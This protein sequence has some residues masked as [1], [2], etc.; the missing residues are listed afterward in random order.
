MHYVLPKYK[1]K[2]SKSDLS[3]ESVLLFLSDLSFPNFLLV[4]NVRWKGKYFACLCVAFE[5]QRPV[6]KKLCR[7]RASYNLLYDGTVLVDGIHMHTLCRMT[8][9]LRPRTKA[10]TTHAY[11]FASTFIIWLWCVKSAK[12][13]EQ[14]RISEPRFEKQSVVFT[15]RIRFV[16][17]MTFQNA[18]SRNG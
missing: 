15:S 14:E 5:I 4:L 7:S 16:V 12:V 6:S 8:L 1:T 17:H 2:V 18:H 9:I 13:F 3:Y 10:K 11:I